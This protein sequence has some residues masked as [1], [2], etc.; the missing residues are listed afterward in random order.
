MNFIFRTIR[1][2]LGYLIYAIDW[3]TRPAIPDRSA[4]KQ[5]ELDAA[6][7]SMALYQF[8]L[9]PFCVRTRRK[10]RRLGLNIETRDARNDPQW[11]AELVAEGGKYQVPC[12]R[13]A[14]DRGNVNWL[15]ESAAINDYLDRRFSG[16]G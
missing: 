15:Y 9:C 12:L 13:I 7:A 2:V 8:K 16:A 6:T 5:S 4:E 10:I 3:L 1:R 11:N 14:D